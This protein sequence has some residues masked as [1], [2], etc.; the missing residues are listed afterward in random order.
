MVCENILTTPPRPM[1]RNGAFSHK[2][3]YITIFLKIWNLKGHQNHITGSRVTAIM[4]KGW[5]FPFGQSGEASRWRWRVCYQRG[6]TRLVYR[7]LNEPYFWV[8]VYLRPLFLGGGGEGIFHECY[9]TQN[10]PETLC[11]IS[12]KVSSVPRESGHSAFTEAVSAMTINSRVRCGN[13]LS[14]QKYT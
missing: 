3:D 1:V 6:L 11:S 14:N 2:I 5:I 10:L 8:F 12:A 4:L 7:D 9:I 13:M